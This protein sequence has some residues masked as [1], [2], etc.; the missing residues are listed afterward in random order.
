MKNDERT[1]KLIASYLLDEGNFDSLNYPQ[2]IEIIN[3]IPGSLN[4]QIQDPYTVLISEN[5]YREDI[6]KYKN[7]LLALK[8]KITPTGEIY[9]PMTYNLLMEEVIQRNIIIRTF[10]KEYPKINENAAIIGNYDWTGEG[11][12]QIFTLLHNESQDYFITF[13]FSQDDPKYNDKV[14]VT[15]SYI[16]ILLDET[17]EAYEELHDTYKDTELY[18]LRKKPKVKRKTLTR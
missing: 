4:Y 14:R 18:L 11:M 5:A 1:N 16:G 8:G 15:E 2:T 10:L 9:L 12:E 7:K 17:Y 6:D 3:T 13:A